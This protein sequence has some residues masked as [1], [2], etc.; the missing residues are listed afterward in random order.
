[1]GTILAQQL[2]SLNDELLIHQMTL[3]NIGAYIFMK[4]TEGRYTYANKL[5]RELFGCPLEDIVGHDDSQFFSLEHSNEIKENDRLVLTQGLTVEKEERNVIKNTGDVRYYWIVKKPLFDQQGNIIGLNGIST[6]ITQQKRLQIELDR[7]QK[8]LDTV[9]NNVDAYIYMKDNQRRFLFINEK[10]AQLF[11]TSAKS[12]VGK[13]SEDILPLEMAENFDI[14]DNKIIT[15]GQAVA[16]EELVTLDNG[17][18][19]YYWT[20]KVP[21]KN[22]DGYVNSF[23]GFSSDITDLCNLR[24]DFEVKASTDELTQLANRRAFMTTCSKELARSK[25]NNQ[26]ISVMIFDIDFFK[27]VNDRYGHHV[28]DIVLSKLANVCKE[29]VRASDLVARLGGEEF[30]VLLPETT[31]AQA[32]Q[33]AEKL[34]SKIEGIE[35]TGSWNDVINITV[36][37]GVTE[38]RPEQETIE[39][40]LI[41]ADRALY[42]AK[43]SGR[44]K[45]LSEG[46]A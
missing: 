39:K 38:V 28:G 41:R 32:M 12:V 27:K 9:I 7:K 36:S 37:I 33:T 43:N 46:L 2:Q 23:I 45:A 25:R 29:S 35:F 30:A 4:D 44:N 3:D 42:R 11:G 20:T 31:L 10:T 17:E 40:P 6:D 16:G 15:S 1:M 26:P 34:R 24:N 21:I 5:V 14:L 18:T 8:L 22:E 19:K 13:R